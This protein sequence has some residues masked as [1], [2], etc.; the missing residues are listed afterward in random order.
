MIL[1]NW[2]YNIVPPAKQLLTLLPTDKVYVCAYHDF[3][4]NSNYIPTQYSMIRFCNEDTVF[5]EKYIWSRKLHTDK[6]YACL[7]VLKAYEYPF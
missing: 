2:Y 5:S 7:S 6:I 3:R 1:H 4:I